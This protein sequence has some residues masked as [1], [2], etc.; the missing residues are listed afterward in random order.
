MSKALLGSED[1]GRFESEKKNE[2]GSAGDRTPELRIKSSWA[3][4]A[5]AHPAVYKIPVK[6]LEAVQELKD[7]AEKLLKRALEAKEVGTLPSTLDTLLSEVFAAINDGQPLEK[8][9]R[10]ILYTLLDGTSMGDATAEM[11]ARA[12]ASA[13]GLS[14]EIKA[15]GQFGV[16]AAD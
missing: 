12:A 2:Q 5:L 10:D 14:K 11:L 16:S 13:K 7:Q 3:N 6:N 8:A 9:A 15:A 4:P 1:H